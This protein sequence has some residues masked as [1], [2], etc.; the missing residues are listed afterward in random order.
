MSAPLDVAGL[1]RELIQQQT[2][3]ARQHAALLQL[4]G[5]TLRVQRLLVEHVLGLAA[6][7]SEPPLPPPSASTPERGASPLQ[8]MRTDPGAAP[9][10]PADPGAPEPG[11]PLACPPVDSPEQ[12][13][14]ASEDSPSGGA[15]RLSVVPTT[16]SAAPAPGPG[17]PAGSR[18][19]RYL[20]APSPP[21][22][23]PVTQQDVERIMR[24]H[25]VGDAAQL[26][27]QFGEYKGATLVQVAER[28]PDY[29]RQLALTAQRP[30]VRAVARQLVAVLEASA[31]AGQGTRSSV[32]NRGAATR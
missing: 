30:Q 14:S 6:A 9:A 32:R 4:Q 26:V 17:V 10:P 13:A 12:P 5:E 11:D 15:V 19:T 25:E 21:H 7:D 24:L 16:E 28:D 20:K 22:A 29:V 3:L 27:L 18:A 2:L 23:K 8:I 1:V 31:R